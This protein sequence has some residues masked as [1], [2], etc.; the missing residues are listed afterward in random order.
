MVR[1]SSIP[2]HSVSFSRHLGVYSAGD[3][4]I[5]EHMIMLKNNEEYL[6]MSDISSKIEDSLCVLYEK[7]SVEDFSLF[8]A[9][10]ENLKESLALIKDSIDLVESINTGIRNGAYDD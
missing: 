8:D 4:L 5:V 3:Y 6:P 9:V 2:C 1:E 7:L 10:S